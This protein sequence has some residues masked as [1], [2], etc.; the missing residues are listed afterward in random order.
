MTRSLTAAHSLFGALAVGPLPLSLLALLLLP[1]GAGLLLPLL[2]DASLQ[3]GD[4]CVPRWVGQKEVLLAA[5]AG[6]HR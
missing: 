6:A 2:L 1:A 3:R 5:G 4:T